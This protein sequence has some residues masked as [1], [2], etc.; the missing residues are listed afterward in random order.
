M[1][2]ASPLLFWSFVALALALAVAFVAAV[3]VSASARPTS[4]PRA[5]RDAAIAALGAAAWLG[6]TYAAAQSG[7]LSFSTRPPTMLFL[8]VATAAVSIAIGASRLGRRLATGIPLAAL[9][10]VQGFRVAVE[11]ILHR[12]YR[13]GLMPIQMSFSGLNFDILSGLSAIAVALVLLRKPGSLV[14]V[15]VWNTAG[16]VLLANILTIALLSAPTPL[17]FFHNEPANVWITQAPWVWLPSVF[18][19]AAVVGHILVYRRI[20]HEMRAVIPS[21]ARNLRPAEA[22]GP[23]PGR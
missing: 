20:R 22:S 5:A 23:L 11:L 16:V 6:L 17:R 15:R 7:R 19:L 18:V 8:L 2:N 14:L 13:E 12:A 10:G 1:V 9:V 4:S 21:E 3:Y